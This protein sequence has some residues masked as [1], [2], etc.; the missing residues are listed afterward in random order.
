MIS[1]NVYIEIGSDSLQVRAGEAGLELALERLEN[2]RLNPAQREKVVA[3][4]RDFLKSQRVRPAQRAFC[5]IDARGV[6]LRRLTVPTSAKEEFQRLLLLQIEREYPLAPEHLAWGWRSLGTGS[7]KTQDVAIVAVKRE[8]VQE[9]AEILRACGLTPE[10]TLG[11]VARSSLLSGPPAA[12][13]LLDLGRHH[14]ELVSFE[15]GVPVSIF[16]IPREE[17]PDGYQSLAKVLKAHAVGQRLY[18][19]GTRV[20]LDAAAPQLA[21]E[22][23]VACEPIETPSGAGCSAAIAGLQ[24]SCGSG[25]SPPLVFQWETS[26][27]VQPAARQVPLKWAA[28]A[29]LLIL[30]SLSLRYAEALLQ[31]PHLAR[32]LA[33]ITRYRD[34]LPE[35]D[36]E[37]SFLQ[38]LKTNQPPY[39]APIFAMAN[40]SPGGARVDSLSMNRRGDLALRAT[41]RD[42][43]QVAEF[44][45]R[46]TSSQAAGSMAAK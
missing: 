7:H 11:A 14:A 42:S 25:G 16:V 33:E 24:R 40:A 4:L 20:P 37:L 13:S 12:Y 44:R 35:V 1:R 22:I 34:R 3:S 31:R 6:S 45:T 29:V 9:Y 8:I 38:Y 18:V 15:H 10:F 5:A 43:S 39:L 46:A 28:L 2:R 41:L 23:G 17:T 19:S 21:R 32:R 27:E 36:R 26:G 30:V